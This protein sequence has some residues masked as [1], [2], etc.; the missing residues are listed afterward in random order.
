MQIHLS[1]LKAWSRQKAPPH[2]RGKYARV[3]RR[4][5]VVWINGTPLAVPA[6]A[7]CAWMR[8]TGATVAWLQADTLNLGTEDSVIRLKCWRDDVPCEESFDAHNTPNCDHRPIWDR[9]PM[10]KLPAL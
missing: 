1:T 5:A 10:A 8:S 2:V 7:A 6:K 4:F 3:W 9:A